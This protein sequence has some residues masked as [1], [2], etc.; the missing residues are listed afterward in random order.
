MKWMEKLRGL[1]RGFLK[2]PDMAG[3][4]MPQFYGGEIATGERAHLSV[5][6]CCFAG[7]RSPT[8][9][10]YPRKTV[11]ALEATSTDRLHWLLCF[12]LGDDDPQ[13]PS[14]L[15]QERWRYL[16]TDLLNHVGEAHE[17]LSGPVPDPE[18]IAFKI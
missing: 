8:C 4:E 7:R 2:S 16:A 15:G 10:E 1:E 12:P 9:D 14:H 6:V 18:V 17:I 3:V 13:K 11:A 5:M